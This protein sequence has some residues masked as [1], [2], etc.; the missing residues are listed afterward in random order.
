MFLFF[1]DSQSQNVLSFFFFSMK[2]SFFLI[3]LGYF[4]STTERFKVI[5]PNG[6]YHY[7]TK[8]DFDD[9]QVIFL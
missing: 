5:F 7:I 4:T 8:N 3:L 9:V 6:I 1:K 2:H